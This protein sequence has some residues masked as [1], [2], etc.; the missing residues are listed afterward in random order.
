MLCDRDKHYHLERARMEMDLAYQAEH[1]SVAEAHMR[2]SALHMGRIK[3]L[4]ER[5]DGSAAALRAQAAELA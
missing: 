5:C 4:D 1:R 3:A 2:L